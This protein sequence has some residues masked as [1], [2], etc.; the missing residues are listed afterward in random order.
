MLHDDLTYNLHGTLKPEQN[1]AVIR[2]FGSDSRS[3]SQM[4]INIKINSFCSS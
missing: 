2:N 4:N 1:C 3:L